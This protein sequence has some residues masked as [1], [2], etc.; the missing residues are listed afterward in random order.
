[1]DLP[2]GY[3]GSLHTDI[4]HVGH[5]RWSTDV[6]IASGEIGDQV[7]QVLRREEVLPARGIVAADHVPDSHALPPF[8]VLQLLS[9][10]DLL[11]AVHAVEENDIA[12]HLFEQ[13]A[14]WR[15]T[16]AAGDKRDLLSLAHLLGKESDWS[17]DDHA[18]TWLDLADPAGEVSKVLHRDTKRL[19]VRRSGERER[20]GLPYESR[21]KEA[22]EEELSGA[23]CHSLEV[24]PS[25]PERHYSWSLD[26]H[27]CHLA[28][29]LE[30]KEERQEQPE[31]ENEGQGYDVECRPAAGRPGI[32]EKVVAG[33]QLVEPRECNRE[34]RR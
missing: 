8:Q 25:Q 27:V 5:G 2:G 1:M 6:D 20:M 22:P 4:H 24:A 31:H 18:R 3:A 34:V 28:L 26:S 16:H 12:E 10:D 13:R 23:R 15:D 11:R 14:D 9:E 30:G 32:E 17:H 19:P 7:L 21:R 33:G 29:V